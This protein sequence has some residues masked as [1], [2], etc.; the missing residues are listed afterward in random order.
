M[1]ES[2]RSTSPLMDKQTFET[3]YHP[4]RWKTALGWERDGI[5]KVI[6]I[7]RRCFLIRDD[8]EKLI[9][10]GGKRFA[11]GWRRDPGDT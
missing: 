6:R 10:E 8:I 1:T 11:Y 4:L 7:G 2:V 9:A 3:D 5:V